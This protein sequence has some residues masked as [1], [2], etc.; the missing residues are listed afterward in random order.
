MTPGVFQLG[1]E[2]TGHLSDAGTVGVG[3]HAEQVDFSSVHLDYEEHVEGSQ[4]DRVD[5]EEVDGQDAFDLGRQE[6]A[7]GG[8][9]ASGPGDDGGAGQRRR[10]Y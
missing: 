1:R 6:L 5:G 2:V 7:T 4:G 8:T 3:G 9:R 10:W